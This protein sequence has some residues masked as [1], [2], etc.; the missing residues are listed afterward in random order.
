MTWLH[1]SSQRMNSLPLSGDVQE[2]A[3]SPPGMVTIISMGLPYLL[4]NRDR[5]TISQYTLPSILTSTEFTKASIEEYDQDH[6]IYGN[7]ITGY[8][9]PLDFHA[10]VN[11]D[12]S[13][14]SH[15]KLEGSSHAVEFYL[16][17]ESEPSETSIVVD[18]LNLLSHLTT[19]NFIAEASLAGQFLMATVRPRGRETVS[20]WT[21]GFIWDVTTEELIT[22]LY[23]PGRISL[24]WLPPSVFLR[25]VAQEKPSP[26]GFLEIFC[27]PFVSPSESLSTPKQGRHSMLLRRVMLPRFHRHVDLELSD[28]KIIFDTRS[29]SWGARSP[30]FSHSVPQLR[31]HISPSFQDKEAHDQLCVFT[32]ELLISPTSDD[33]DDYFD[34]LA[35]EQHKFL[36]ITHA[37]A[38]LFAYPG[39]DIP[40]E[41]WGADSAACLYGKS[42]HLPD[43]NPWVVWGSRF[44]IVV[45]EEPGITEDDPDEDPPLVQCAVHVLDFN[46]LIVA[47]F[48]STQAWPRNH[49]PIRSVQD[50]GA[51]VSEMA[52]CERKEILE[53]GETLDDPSTY[54]PFPPRPRSGPFQFFPNPETPESSTLFEEWPINANLP[55]VFTK[56]EFSAKAYSAKLHIDSE[57][58]VLER[59]VNYEGQWKKVLDILTF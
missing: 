51:K 24:D 46:P 37:S 34:Y 9:M 47:R 27:P 40:W 53:S 29:A 58:L 3:L 35:I 50:S 25:A 26:K 13:I 10:G 17:K 5:D 44:A 12:I 11:G 21:H 28:L 38:L 20:E 41:M 43:A 39:L 4:E 45:Q 31:G 33:E 55:Y 59:G 8:N 6:Y 52:L 32:I 36:F 18:T 57:R 30:V 49:T 42:A 23:H 15:G 1:L 22:H 54:K 19:L 56:L 48:G 14:W 16:A 7:S 2:V